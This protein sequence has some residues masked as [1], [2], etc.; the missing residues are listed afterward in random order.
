MK[1]SSIQKLVLL[2][3]LLVATINS[4]AQDESLFLGELEFE[5]FN[6][7]TQYELTITVSNIG[8]LFSGDSDPNCPQPRIY[9]QTYT[10]LKFLGG[11]CIPDFTQPLTGASRTLSS[12]NGIVGWR[13]EHIGDAV[14]SPFDPNTGDN[15]WLGYG[16]YKIEITQIQ[17]SPT[18]AYTFYINYL[19][20]NYPYDDKDISIEYYFDR[21][22]GDRVIIAPENNADITNVDGKTYTVWELFGQESTATDFFLNGSVP[23]S[24]LSSDQLHTS[25]IVNGNI[26]VP[27]GK[28]LTLAPG[29]TVTINSGVTVSV[30][31]T[32][33]V[34]ANTTITGGG[35]IV[36][37]PVLQSE[38]SS[39]QREHR[40][41]QFRGAAQF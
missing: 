9:S 25:V 14:P 26:T 38:Q 10:N 21:S 4:Q 5:L 40:R 6:R 24:G 22:F 17:P 12:A 15:H 23:L 1:N 19:D 13:F 27:S 3:N 18:D 41:F 20:S 11:N 32:L 36:K 30:E 29:N 2:I 31:G 8:M 35:T 34:P 33:S 37:Q 28:T 39:P 7:P 16:L